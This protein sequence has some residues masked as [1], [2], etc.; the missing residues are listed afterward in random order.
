MNGHEH[1]YGRFGGRDAKSPDGYL[2]LPALK[3]AMRSALTAHQQGPAPKP[4]PTTLARRSVE[5]YPAAKRLK[6][7]TCIHCHQVYDF[8]RV[9]KV[10]A[11]TWRLEDVWEYPLPAT[12]G[13][14]LD[15]DRGNRVK[16][17][18]SG[19]AAERAGLR[20]GDELLMVNGQS[21][22][23]FADVQ[24]GLHLARNVT[25]LRVE[26]RRGNQSNS[27]SIDLPADWRQTDI[28]WRASMWGLEPTPCVYGQDLTKREKRDLGLPEDGMAFRQG[29][30]VPSQAKAAGIKAGDIIFGI[31]GKKR[32]LTMLQ[33]NAFVRLNF[34]TGD[35]ITF[36][37]LR[38][39][40]RLDLPMTLPKEV[41]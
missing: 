28:G 34:K 37:V 4:K 10:A 23:A 25:S 13:M 39:G 8:R 22:A 19:S 29:E 18:K 2:T 30:F 15:P 7:D 36:N 12:I 41:R 32:E 31:D 24:Y 20:D 14:I 9:E 27:A 21:T 11:G 1:T 38:D 5:Q 40:K 26:W 35:G 33:F 16:S 17:V 6:V 3:H